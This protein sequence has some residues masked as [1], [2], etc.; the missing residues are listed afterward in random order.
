MPD[1]IDKKDI[2]NL[3]DEAFLD[4]YKRYIE[5]AQFSNNIAFAKDISDILLA[6]FGHTPNFNEK[7]PELF[8]QYQS[9]LIRARWIAL[10]LLKESDVLEMFEKYFIEG[11]AMAEFIDIWEKLRSRLMNILVVENRDKLKKSIRKSLERN[12]QNITSGKIEAGSDKR[13]PTIGNWILEFTAEL[14]DNMFD[15]VKE[16]QYFINGKNSKGLSKTEKANLA[17]LLDIYRRC[18]RSSETTEGV[19]E[20]IPVDTKNRVG[21]IRDGQFEEIKLSDW[22]ALVDEMK[23]L[24]DKDYSAV[25]APTEM[26]EDDAEK[27]RNKLIE[28]FMGSEEEREKIHKEE[29]N[30]EQVSKDGLKPVVEIFM[31]A[32][33]QKD[34]YKAIASLRVVVEKGDLLVELKNNK[35]VSVIAKEILQKNYKPEALADF[36][37]NGFT[38]PY[39]SIFLQN[40]FKEKMNLDDAESARFGVQLENMLV[41]KGHT[42]AQGMVYGDLVSGKY[43]WQEV[44][45][46]GVK[47]SIPEQGN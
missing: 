14:G 16:S 6:L 40:V 45:D 8:K 47:L 32:I 20:A 24:R 15:K 31:E 41:E 26:S 44:R 7:N 34:K 21:T 12:S 28:G 25:S 42:E 23:K 10:P 17:V 35:R 19:E 3:E 11:L 33:N 18:G 37:R 5:N 43:V 13:N 4:K 46:E 1:K 30:L 38:A 29:T 9:I 36:Q 2:P 27:Q 39:L 22:K